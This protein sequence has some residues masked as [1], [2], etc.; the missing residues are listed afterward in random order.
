MCALI[1]V[2]V[3]DTEENKRSEY[4]KRTLV[5]LLKT[6]DFNKHR[7]FVIDNASCEDTKDF[8]R[9]DFMAAIK[10]KGFDPENFMLITSDKNLGTSGAINLAWLYREPY[11][12]VIKMDNDVVINQTGWVEQMEEAI[13]RD[14]QIGII[15]LKRKDIIQTPWHPDPNFRSELIMLPHENG[16]RWICVERT[17]DI[18]G[19]C[20]MFN[21]ALLDKTGYS[22]QPGLYGYEDVLFCHRSHIAGFYNCFLNHIDIDHIDTGGG[23]YQHWKEKHSG[24]HTAEMIQVFKEYVNGTRPI[25][26]NP[27]ENEN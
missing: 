3:Y 7:L 16:Q 23:E 10:I 13:A 15:G 6:V 22:Y 9:N 4:T 1:S 17:Q 26:Y 5:S 14:P 8:L 24:E 18:I 27:F 20:T 11:E 19:T 12:H 21:S 2:A 25:Y